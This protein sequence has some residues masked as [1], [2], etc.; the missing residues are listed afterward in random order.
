MHI[1]NIQQPLDTS[2][3]FASFASSKC[4][5]HPPLELGIDGKHPVA[6]QP[7]WR[8][9]IN[10]TNAGYVFLTTEDTSGS[11]YQEYGIRSLVFAVG[12]LGWILKVAK[13]NRHTTAS[14]GY[15]R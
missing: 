3:S 14:H 6:I 9:G 4:H 12:P 11:S 1:Y 15:A 13:P 7:P 2:S 8:Q 5:D 10:L